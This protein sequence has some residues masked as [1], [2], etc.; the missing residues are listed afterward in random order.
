MLPFTVGTVTESFDGVDS[1]ES[2]GGYGFELVVVHSQPQAKLMVFH[3]SPL[4]HHELPLKVKEYV[5][6]FDFIFPH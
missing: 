1:C 4:E 3:T 5:L 2:D 6:F